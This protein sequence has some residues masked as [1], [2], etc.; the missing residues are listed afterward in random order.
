M[1]TDTHKTQ[2]AEEASVW[3]AK[4]TADYVTDD[5]KQ[6]FIHWLEQ[7]PLHREE[8]E[9][10]CST[11]MK[12]GDTDPQ[13]IDRW[14]AGSQPG[15]LSSLAEKLS[16][17]A[18][19]AWA[20][21]AL[22]AVLVLAVSLNL[23]FPSIE[24]SS[25]KTGIGERR[26]VYL[27]DGSRLT[28]NTDSSLH[29]VMSDDSRNISLEQ[30]EVFFSVAHDKERPFI[31]KAEQGEVR[32]LGTK[33]NV[34]AQAS[35][36]SVSI[37]EG[38]V[39]LSL[40]ANS[41]GTDKVATKSTILLT[42][43]AATF[44]SSGELQK[45]QVIDMERVIA[46]QDGKFVFKGTPLQEVVKEIN[47]YIDATVSIED[48]QLSGLRITGTFATDRI[49]ELLATIEKATPVRVLY[50]TQQNIVLVSK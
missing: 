16:A 47:R 26:E 29:I 14:M 34:R 36:V 22:A 27:S 33:F 25:Y 37:L 30:G 13:Q 2:V 35:G 31:V 41:S 4:L 23:W 8:Y 10:L 17:S 21:A 19:I 38:K 3:F 18:G 42:G 49:P 39:E 15:W 28:L 6:A 46:W 11:W 1:N 20:G 7:S 50:R 43:E 9:S 12:V 24:E 5:V 32:V 45:S 44:S 48:A 40:P